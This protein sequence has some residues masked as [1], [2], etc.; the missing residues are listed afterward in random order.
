MIMP[1]NYS[2]VAEN[3]LSYVNGGGDFFVDPI[4]SVKTLNE[5]IVKY[6]GNAYSGAIMKAFI[7]NWFIAN[8]SDKTLDVVFGG[9]KDL[10]TY[11]IDFDN[12]EKTGLGKFFRGVTNTI[13]V[14]AG[15]YNLGKYD[16][17]VGVEDVG[18]L[19]LNPW[20]PKAI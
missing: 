10:F 15:I 7:G 4:T 3:E 14:L 11:G 6:I 18:S 13:G 8:G 9:I 20:A 12:K 5:N 17:A 1:A 2:V 16:G 19:N